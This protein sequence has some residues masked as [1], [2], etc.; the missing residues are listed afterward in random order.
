MPD[1]TSTPPPPTRP[2]SP[3]RVSDFLTCP[4]LYRFRAI[5]RLPEPES[6]AALRGTLVHEVLEMLFDLPAAQRTLD[7]AVSLVRPRWRAMSAARPEVAAA[8]S[9][10]AL[11]EWLARA[12]D[13]LETYFAL[14]DPSRLEPAARELPV[15]AELP[16]GVVLHGR[17][18]RVDQA[19]NGALRVIDYKTG[20]SPYVGRET[21][22]MFQLRM[23]ALALWSMEGR[24]P[25]LLQLL[26]LGDGVVLTDRPDPADLRRTERKVQAIADAIGRAERNDDF[27]PKPSVACRWCAHC[28][29]CPAFA[30]D[31]VAV[32]SEDPTVEAAPLLARL[33]E[34]RQH[35]EAPARA[36]H[37]PR[38]A[39]ADGITPS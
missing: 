19:R 22:A 28:A 20:R 7:Q 18:D 21:A 8:I 6:P 31:V 30:S 34:A 12:G 1:T 24:V 5:D 16:S 27:R 10:D 33:D 15:Y 11:E 39:P 23:Y 36:E 29:L 35:A 17:V 26:Y 38:P 9:P 25:A 13:R 14:E 32:P 37:P 3:S 4:L 2:L